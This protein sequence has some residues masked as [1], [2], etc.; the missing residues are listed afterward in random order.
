MPMLTYASAAGH[1]FIN[2]RLYLP[3]QWAA[4]PGRR[5]PAGVPEH[6]AFAAKPRLV[7]DMLG[8]ELAA[9]TPLRFLTADSGYGR[10]PGLRAFCHDEQTLD[11]RPQ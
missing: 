10:D 6:V 8:E 1:A 4:D 5:V 3:E 11:H 7:I 2:R 9:G